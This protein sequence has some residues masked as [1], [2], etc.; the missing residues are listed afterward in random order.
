[1][2]ERQNAGLHLLRAAVQVQE[3]V[4]SYLQAVQKKELMMGEQPNGQATRVL[5]K[6]GV[7]WNVGNVRLEVNGLGFGGLW[8]DGELVLRVAGVTIEV[9]V[10]HP[11]V[12]TVKRFVPGDKGEPFMVRGLDGTDAPAAPVAE[13]AA[14]AAEEGRE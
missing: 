2:A 12:M 4:Q 9:V 10:G 11:P 14:E 5:V 3:Q 8:V 13:P 1:M 6:D 7:K